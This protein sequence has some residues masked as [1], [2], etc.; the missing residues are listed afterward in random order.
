MNINALLFDIDGVLCHGT[1]PLP[2]AIGFLNRFAERPHAFVTNN[3][4][5]TPREVAERLTRMGFAPP[6]ADLIITSAEATVRWLA[7]ERPG[8]RYY[9]VGAEG[10]HHALNSAGTEDLEDAEFVIVGEGAGLDYGTL[11]RGINLILKNGARLVATNPDLTVDDHWE[12]RHR[13]L[14]GCGTLVTPFAT[15]TGTRPI[16]IGKPEPLLFRMALERLH[17]PPDACLMIGDRPDT[18]IAGAAR[19]GMRTALVRTGRHRPGDPWPPD[20][21]RPDWDVPDLTALERVLADCMG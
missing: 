15:A 14:P 11:T 21:P 4:I 12:G 2:G 13:V 19:I 6:H 3:P 16:V 7:R 9:A 10:L 5:R 1:R 18:D 20:I 17:V 8:F